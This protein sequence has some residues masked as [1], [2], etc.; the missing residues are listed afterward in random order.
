MTGKWTFANVVENNQT[1]TVNS[2]SDESSSWLQRQKTAVLNS[3]LKTKRRMKQISE[4]T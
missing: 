1:Q 2:I 4:D 3:G